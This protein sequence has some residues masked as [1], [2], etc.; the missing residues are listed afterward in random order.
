MIEVWF[1]IATTDDIDWDFKGFDDWDEARDFRR[2]LLK[3][4]WND[5]Q[6]S[7]EQILT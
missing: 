2:H 6:I 7:V 5:D 3:L 4:G 1:Q